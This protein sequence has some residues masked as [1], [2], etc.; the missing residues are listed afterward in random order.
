MRR[1]KLEVWEGDLRWISV[2]L[3]A[4]MRTTPCKLLS[5]DPRVFVLRKLQSDHWTDKFHVVNPFGSLLF[6]SVLHLWKIL[7]KVTR[8]DHYISRVRLTNDLATRK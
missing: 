4:D 8:Q 3:T 5:L 1:K 2:F 7:G 6:H